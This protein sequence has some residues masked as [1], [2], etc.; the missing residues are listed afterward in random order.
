MKNDT[1]Q[2]TG[3][4]LQASAWALI[5]IVAAIV[6]LYWPALG[7]DFVNW[8]D[9]WYVANNQLIQSWSFENLKGI[10]T[11]SVTRNYAPLTVF[12]FLLDH[13]AWGL[14]PTGYHLTNILL[15]V[16][17]SVLVFFLLKQV[18]RSQFVAW[19]TALL[20]AVHPVQV[21]S[22]VWIS[23]RKSLLSASFILAS[24][25]YWF[26]LERS[27]REEGISIGFLCAALLSKAIAVAVPPI[28]LMYD[29][30]VRRKPVGESV[31]RQIVPGFLAFLLLATTMSSQTSI[32]GGLRDHLSLSKLHILAIDTTLLWRY[33]GM[34]L[35]PNSLS[36]LYDPPTT[37][38]AM[39]VIAASIGLIC[40]A[41]GAWSA[42]KKYP[43]VT[44]A[45]ASFYILFL[46]VLNLFPLT[47][48]MNDRYLY[49]PS[50]A[51]FGLAGAG[52]V[53]LLEPAKQAIGRFGVG[54]IQVT[55][56]A[57]SAIAL[58]M[59]THAYLPTWKNSETLW[60]HAVNETPQ[61]MVARIQK[62]CALREQ[63]RDTDAMRVLNAALGD[64]SRDSIDRP[65]VE[66]MLESWLRESAAKDLSRR[67]ET[68]DMLLRLR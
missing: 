38:I 21:E 50:I 53:H 65:R 46:P 42:R 6:W 22:V 55:V 52:L 60:T 47:T 4:R 5:S 64:C 40:V 48:L 54:S 31:A 68:S 32:G 44:L 2:E 3:F 7:F 14:Q 12:S 26:R 51:F 18:T 66:S 17:N 11:E 63:G 29:V 24:L 23:S 57:A 49:L 8:D 13:S 41:A 39:A 1:P 15:H 67:A 56:T 9:P 35:Y 43:L 59:A 19:S 33:V 45:V 10:A 16:V 58:M 61:L 27:S 36:V 62:A 37:G 28:M 30:L 34:L 20:F 25:I